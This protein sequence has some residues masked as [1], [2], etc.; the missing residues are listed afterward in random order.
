MNRLGLRKLSLEFRRLSSNLLNSTDDTADI[1]LSRFLKFINGNELISGIIQDKISGVDYD[2]KKC[3]TIGCSGWADY[4][5]PE[6]EACHIKA[7]YDYLNFIN[8]ENTV[9]VRSQAMNYCWSDKKINT[10]I[11]NFLDMAFK[12]L[13]DFINDQLSMEMIVY[14]EEE[15]AMGGNTYIQNIETVN[16][17][18]SQ[19]NSGVINTYNTTNDTS[20]MLELIDKLLASLP[21][22]QGV[23]AEE[24]ENV[25]DDLEMVQEQLK[26]DNPKK[27]RIGKALVGIKKFAGDFS[28]KLAVTLAA[29]AV[30]GADWGMLL[31]QLE[32]F[33][34]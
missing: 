8:N 10:I 21:E 6:D 16:G 33:I 31:Q 15:K 4:N 29:G 5:P 2:F 24:I 26:T 7:Q 25:K 23:D 14:D 20:F 1:N 22:I 34:R 3:Y 17:S 11:Q 12:S 13:I 9:N 18:A 19:Q 27:N 28:M 32:N 30:T